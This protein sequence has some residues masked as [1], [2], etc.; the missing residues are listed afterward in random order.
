MLYLL[1]TNTCIAYQNR[2]GGIRTHGPFVPN[3]SVNV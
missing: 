2:D 1:E 3:E